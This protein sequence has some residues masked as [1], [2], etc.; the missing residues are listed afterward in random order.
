MLEQQRPQQQDSRPKQ[1]GSRKTRGK[2]NSSLQQR[3]RSSPIHVKHSASVPD[4]NY[5]AVKDSA[6]LLSCVN[7]SASASSSRAADVPLRWRLI[8]RSLAATMNA[9]CTAGVERVGGHVGCSTRCC[10]GTC[11]IDALLQVHRA[12]LLLLHRSRSRSAEAWHAIEHAAIF[13]MMR[14]WSTARPLLTLHV[15]QSDVARRNGHSCPS[16][17]TTSSWS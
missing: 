14:M 6:F 1:S 13:A 11:C 15:L 9:Q 10:N 4:F 12:L 17:R 2:Q 7:H 8:M 5:V 16:R 3:D